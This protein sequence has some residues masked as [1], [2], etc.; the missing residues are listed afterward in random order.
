MFL[1]Y[2]IDIFFLQYNKIISKQN[3]WQAQKRIIKN[4]FNQWFFVSKNLNI[5]SL[6]I[7]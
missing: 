2:E 6:F 7:N 4:D 3:R 5:T 1:I